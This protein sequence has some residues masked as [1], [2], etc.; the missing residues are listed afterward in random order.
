MSDDRADPT[1][2]RPSRGVARARDG[3]VAGSDDRERPRASC[4]VM[5]EVVADNLARLRALFPGVVTEGPGGPAVNVDVLR[6]LV[7]DRVLSDAEE[8]YGLD[9]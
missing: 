2:A 5:G 9:W 3:R 1:A 4:H 8:R 7:G 6:Q